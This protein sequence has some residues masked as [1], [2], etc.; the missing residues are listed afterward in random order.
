M[1]I[2]DKIETARKALHNALKGK[3][4]EEKVLEISR[5]IDKYIIEY[6]KEDKSKKY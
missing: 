4:N 6:Y 3:D 5:E 1:N 2:E